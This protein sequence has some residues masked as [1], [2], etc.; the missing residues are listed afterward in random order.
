MA[1]TEEREQASP[2]NKNKKGG[3]RSRV[4]KE[5][6]PIPLKE[7]YEVRDGVVMYD[8]EETFRHEKRMTPITHTLAKMI[9]HERRKIDTVN[10]AMMNMSLKV[11]EG[12][13]QE[14]MV[15]LLDKTEN[16]IEHIDDNTKF[17]F[18]NDGL[19]IELS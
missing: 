4:K 14:D 2:T 18:T 12:M 1:A 17:L 3:R 13:T 10:R 16:N 15:A 19:P 9:E 6:E 11:S 7:H 8:G 5:I